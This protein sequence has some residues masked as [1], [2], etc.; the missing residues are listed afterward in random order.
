MKN[1]SL[2]Y[3][4]SLIIIAYALLLCSTAAWIYFKYQLDPV[5]LV[6]GGL[7]ILISLY[8]IRTIACTRHVDNCLDKIRFVTSE[9]NQGRFSSRITHIN[10]KDRIGEIAWD[11]NDMLDQLE[12]YFRE[13]ET[14]FTYVTEGKVFRKPQ[15]MGLHGGFITSMEHAD[16]SQQ[17][18]AEVQINSAKN[19]I[20]GNLHQLNASN[21]IKNLKENQEDLANVNHEMEVVQKISG[22]TAEKATESKQSIGHVIRDLNQIVDMVNHMD[23]AFKQLNEHSIRVTKAIKDIVE[24]TDQTNLLALN[25]AIEAAR[26]GEHGRGFAVVADEVRALANHTKDVTQEITPAIQAFK[27]EAERMMVDSEDMKKLVH[28]SNDTITRF[29]DNFTEFSTTARKAY[30]NMTFA[31][32]MSF[33]SLVKMDHIIY[34]QNAYRC[35]EVGADSDE[36]RAVMVDHH[37]CRLGKWYDSGNGYKMFSS[38]PSYAELEPSHKMVHDNVHK[39]LDCIKTNWIRDKNAQ[40]NMVGFFNVAEVGSGEIIRII[41]RLVNERRNSYADGTINVSIDKDE[42]EGSDSENQTGDSDDL[43]FF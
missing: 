1:S 27:D 6:L 30:E 40:D 36:A 32:D 37:N 38:M 13:V 42:T 4:V 2:L 22:S 23:D 26:A 8:A 7:A 28:E 21:L 12:T 9:V 10:R 31:L 16:K 11:I 19:A 33:A 35:L 18:I 43:T 3:R 17:A 39:A 24:I 14:C 25:A 20:L 41:N 5:L 15:T 29:E 34:K